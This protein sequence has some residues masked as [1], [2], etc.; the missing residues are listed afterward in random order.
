M[1]KNI[2]AALLFIF[3]LLSIDTNAQGIYFQ[4]KPQIDESTGGY[5]GRVQPV[6]DV[7]YVK[8]AYPGKTKEQLYDAVVNY[9]KSHRGLKL[10]YT[11]DVKKTFLAYRD[12][13]TI[14][15]K[16][17][18]GADLISLTY[19]GVVTDLKDTLLVSY[20]IASRI[21]ATI[22]DAK[23]TISPGN[24]VVSENDVP[25]N[26]YKFVQPGAGRTQS[27]ISPNGGLLGAATS[28][29]INYKLAYPESVFDPN[30]KIVN[31]GNKKI[32]EDFFDG[33]IV[34][35]KNYLDKNLK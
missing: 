18:C 23:L 19:I 10:D 16:T 5:I 9:V 35:L 32:I 33:Y 14:G 8:L 31:P 26:E 4:V 20:S 13:A 24:D 1:M 22:F 21:F 25:F 15:D 2:R 28:R 29:K 7:Q 12:F 34:D 17:K 6:D 27:S 11:N 30:G 3:M